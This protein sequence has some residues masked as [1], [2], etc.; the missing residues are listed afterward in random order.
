MTQLD[1]ICQLYLKILVLHFFFFLKKCHL[2]LQSLVSPPVILFS[3]KHTGVFPFVWGPCIIYFDLL[4]ENPK[5]CCPKCKHLTNKMWGLVVHTEE[6]AL[7]AEAGFVPAL[8]LVGALIAFS[9]SHSGWLRSAYLPCWCWSFQALLLCDGE[10]SLV[11][12]EKG[13]IFFFKELFK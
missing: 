9:P 10:N 4:W 12:E 7:C 3:C 5:V 8:S 11:Q 6:R 13:Q 1:F 2:F